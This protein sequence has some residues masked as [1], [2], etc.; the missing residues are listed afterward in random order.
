MQPAYLRRYLL[1]IALG[2]LCLIGMTQ[3]LRAQAP[4]TP[5]SGVAPVGLQPMKPISQY[6]NDIW[7][8]EQGLSSNGIRAILQTNQG[9]LWLATANGLTRFDGVVFTNYDKGNTKT[10]KNNDLSSLTEGENGTLWVGSLGGGVVKYE[11]GQFVENLGKADGLPDDMVNAVTWDG[12]QL[13]V[14][15]NKGLA[16]LEGVKFHQRGVPNELRTVEISVMAADADGAVWVGTK[17]GGL[18]YLKGGRAIHYGEAE[19]I[20][21]PFI[22]S[23]RPVRGGLAWVGTN[24]EG[25]YKLEGG[26]VVQHL[27][28]K[29][30]GLPS[31]Y[32][33]DI[34]VD[35]FSSLWVA[36]AEGVARVRNME[37]QKAEV[38]NKKAGLSYNTV[39]CLGADK[40]G[41][42]WIGTSRGGL[43]RLR[44]G[45]FLNYTVNDGLK[46]ELV[47][48]ILPDPRDGSFWFATDGGV[49]QLKDGKLQTPAALNTLNGKRVR[50]VFMDS[51]RN[52]WFCTYSGMYKYTGGA[53]TLYSTEQGLPSEL[54]R[55]VFEDS[56]GRLWIGTRSGLARYEN[57]KFTNY[58]KDELDALANGTIHYIHEDKQNNLWI[59]TDGS[60]LVFM[61]AD[62]SKPKVYSLADGLASDILYKIYEDT[63]GRL[64][65]GTNGGINVFKDGKFATISTEQGLVS[66]SI[67]QIID[68]GKQTFWMTTDMGIMSVPKAGLMDILNG[69]AKT[70]APV[71]YTK[72]D[73]LK[74][75]ECTANGWGL[76]TEDGNLW[77]PTIAGVS[78][79]DPAKL[80]RTKVV[81]PVLIER[82]VG[83]ERE[84]DL[85]AGRLNIDANNR[86]KLEVHF[87]CLTYLASDKLGFQFK[88]DGF[89]QEWV[90][91]SSNRVAYYTNLPAGDY[92]F[93]VKVRTPDG[94]WLPNEASLRFT[95][96][97][98]FFET[99]WF[100]ILVVFGSIGIGVG[101]YRWRVREYKKREE[102]LQTT[103]DKRTADLKKQQQKTESANTELQQTLNNL[104]QAQDQLVQSEKLAA[105][106]TLVAG[107]AHEINTPLGAINA[108]AGNL[109]KT[110][111]LTL[112]TLPDVARLLSDK[113][114]EQFHKLIDRTLQ[115]SGVLSSREE[116]QYKKDVKNH[117]EKLQLADPEKL[118]GMLVKTG[119]FDGLEPF[120]ELFHHAQADK[121][122]EMAGMIGRLRLNIDNIALAVDKTQKIVFALKSYSH[123]Q[124]HEV[125]VQLNL[126]ENVETVLTIYSNQIRTGIELVTNF[127]PMEAIYGFPDQLN[128]VWTNLITN[129][130]QAMEG[131]GTL[132]IDVERA[133]AKHQRV[134]IIDSGPGIPP[135]V[136]ARIFEPFFTTKSQGQGTGLGLDICNKII[137]KHGGEITVES[138]PGRTAFIV[139]LPNEMVYI[140][141]EGAEA[142]VALQAANA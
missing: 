17:A 85:N 76:R 21:S 72:G 128:Q 73:G 126:V 4:A 118:A 63:E 117:L 91:A 52:M 78:V 115:F 3:K 34:Y 141:E 104:K 124:S 110:L 61:P 9:Y 89:D 98:T 41:S 81:P 22:R 99:I 11:A 16:I 80:V 32:I 10:F 35:A 69:K 53:T 5:K 93:R 7:T 38:F 44:D 56:K 65:I 97:P 127:T 47:H 18:Y 137:R 134:R 30:T 103:V 58:K 54:T 51:K 107:V 88:L 121:V 15:T 39:L 131:K 50:G 102:E 116:R 74:S 19:G 109:S 42:L 70:V 94:E 12:K 37:E 66:S 108:A 36:T 20:A 130:I 14:G 57:A 46:N 60:G 136:F 139:T 25:L 45:K 43:N 132:Q 101:I 29:E 90:N 64:W 24:G 33:H 111:P 113:E 112:N 77:F 84:Y 26:R 40:E 49:S 122:I 71:V 87:S 142:P 123:R 13:W 92:T 79:L 129:A 59:T 86:R 106:G 75:N 138:V 27:T 82:L 125:P 8:T 119:V 68:D 100:Y 140:P 67:Y 23:L 62:G 120:T 95:V 28:K 2:V 114:E 48:G 135:D 96:E 133:D 83:E 105:L 6:A 1:L 31:D 55:L